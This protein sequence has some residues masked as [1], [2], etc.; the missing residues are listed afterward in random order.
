MSGLK[1]KIGSVLCLYPPVSPS[2]PEMEGIYMFHWGASFFED[3]PLVEFIYLVFTCTP[4]EVTVG[5]SGLRCCVPCLLSVIIS[6]CL[7]IQGRIPWRHVLVSW[8]YDQPFLCY[9]RLTTLFWTSPAL[10]QPLES[11]QEYSIKMTSCWKGTKIPQTSYVSCGRDQNKNLKLRIW[12]YDACKSC[13]D[14][15]SFESD[16]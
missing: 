13:T 12:L 1:C 8:M 4:G 3:V 10:T 15:M 14:F 7:L 6:L 5:N 9:Q 11:S 16:N 2:V